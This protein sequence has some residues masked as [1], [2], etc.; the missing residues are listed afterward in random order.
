VPIAL[1]SI[2][3]V[4]RYRKDEPLILERARAAGEPV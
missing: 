1:L 3:A 2:Y 4:M